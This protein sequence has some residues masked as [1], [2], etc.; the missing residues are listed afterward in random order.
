LSRG[1]FF[2][3]HSTAG[4]DV[5]YTTPVTEKRIALALGAGAA[6]GL[7]HVGVLR[8]LEEDGVEVAGIA[9]TS[10]GSI[11]GA[12]H[13]SGMAAAELEAV[14]A[15]VDWKRLTRIIVRSVGGAAFRDLVQETIGRGMV[16]E[17][18]IPFAAVACDLQ[19]GEEVVLSRGRLAEA[20]LASSAIPGLLP[21]SV[22]DGVTLVDGGIV[23]PVP[24]TAA[25]ETGHAPV[26][27]NNVLR[28]SSSR[29]P[30]SPVIRRLIRG[31]TPAPLL[32]HIEKFIADHPLPKGRDSRE[33]EN[34][35]GTVMRSFHIMQ[36][37]LAV[38]G[39]QA[40]LLI[41]PQVGHIGWFEFE[42]A[43]EIMAAGYEAYREAGG[44]SA[45]L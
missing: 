18:A 41:E 24:V 35:L 29:S 33:P 20:V 4:N 14:F 37:H 6:K 7:A 11:V 10:M 45:V 1:F 34:R 22:I 8:G 15:S 31:A 38:K 12:L 36:N 25:A 23:T 43:T 13:A 40:A 28:P 16:E 32:K 30:G 2:R 19:S 21:P 9:G 27:A 5:R 3:E 39:E 17:L 44:V 26:L 42:R